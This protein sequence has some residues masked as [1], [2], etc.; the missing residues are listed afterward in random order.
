MLIILTHRLLVHVVNS[1]AVPPDNGRWVSHDLV[2]R[3][4]WNSSA[5]NNGAPDSQKLSEPI[6][7]F[8]EEHFASSKV[9]MKM[10]HWKI[11]RQVPTQATIILLFKLFYLGVKL[12]VAYVTVVNKT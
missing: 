5:A 10:G 9:V 11:H 7:S 1:S 12:F 6:C 2:G 3:L 4:F 8:G